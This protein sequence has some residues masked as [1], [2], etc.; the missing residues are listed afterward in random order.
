MNKNP[1]QERLVLLFELIANSVSNAKHAPGTRRAAEVEVRL[2]GEI[3]S[4]FAYPELARDALAALFPEGIPCDGRFFDRLRDLQMRLGWGD[5]SDKAVGMLLATAGDLLPN[6]AI[7]SLLRQLTAVNGPY[8]VKVLESLHVL[9]ERQVLRTEFAVEWFPALFRHLGKAFSS[10]FWRTLEVYCEKHQ[11][12]AIAVLRC[13][14][15]AQDEAEISIAAYMLG[16]LRTLQYAETLKTELDQIASKFE[17]SP[18][19]TTRSIYHRSWIQ[20]A[21]RGKMNLEDITKLLNQMNGGNPEEQELAF[22]IICRSML[23]PKISQDCF[24]CGFA[25]LQGKA[26]A[27]IPPSAKYHIVDL[28]AHLAAKGRWEATELVMA[29]QPIDIE[30]KG[31]WHR[32]EPFLVCRLQTDLKCFEDLGLRLAHL[33]KGFWLKFLQEPD[34][35]GWLLSE[36]KGKDLGSMVGQLVLSKEAGCRKLGLF[37]FDELAQKTLPPELMDRVAEGGLRLALHELQRTLVHGDAIGR[38]LIALIPCAQRV[39]SGFQEELYKE[40]LLQSKNY[41]GSCQAEFE[42]QADVFPILRKVLNEAGN[43]FKSLCQLQQSPIN[44]MDVAGYAYAVRLCRRRL[45]EEV[46]KGGEARSVFMQLFKKTQLLYGKKWSSFN[47][48]KLTEASALQKIS[49][50]VEI[51]RLEEIDPEGMALRRL[52]ASINLAALSANH[53]V[54]EEDK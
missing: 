29:I 9:A 24:D 44:A 20:T 30:H 10:G 3:D 23:S 31:T 27:A 4:M 51:P 34:G 8:F 37:L 18:V 12:N 52:N 17:T 43:Y 53:E 48:G 5:L 16:T 19:A 32:L 54:K 36:M 35:M 26:N 45:S 40:L 41:A 15:E 6:N 1:E 42:R 49:S 38:Y 21:W 39:S 13:F 46:R 47:D 11:S 50:S 22:W 33:S 14:S 7:E 25:W 2:A 28:A